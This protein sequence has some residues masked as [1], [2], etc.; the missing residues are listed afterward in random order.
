MQDDLVEEIADVMCISRRGIFDLGYLDIE[1]L[2]T[3]WNVEYDKPGYN[4]SYQAYFIFSR[5]E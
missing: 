3:K 4:E 5:K 1:D 2:Y